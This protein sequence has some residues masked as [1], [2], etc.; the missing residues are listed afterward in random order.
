MPAST[1]V[2]LVAA[3][4]REEA[5]RSQRVERHVDAPQPGR[6][7]IVRELGQLHAVRRQRDVDAERREHLNEPGHVRPHERL[8]AG[9]PDASNRTAPRRRRATRAI[10]S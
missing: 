10:S 8:A 9:E 6:R 4:Q 3:G 5:F 2:E 1:R 7:E